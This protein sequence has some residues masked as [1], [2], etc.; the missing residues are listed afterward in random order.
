ML[1]SGPMLQLAACA[2]FLLQSRLTDGGEARFVS[3]QASYINWLPL[4]CQGGPSRV[5]GGHYQGP[6]RG[7]GK[8]RRGAVFGQGY[9]SGK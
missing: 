8:P 7:A 9:E 2:G 6:R 5:V 3:V 4:G 1:A